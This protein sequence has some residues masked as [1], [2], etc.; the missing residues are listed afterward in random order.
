MSKP[1]E[2][3][4]QATV[5]KGGTAARKTPMGIEPEEFAKQQKAAAKKRAA[6][7]KKA[8]ASAEE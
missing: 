6:A 8:Q 5:V 1:R 7:K 4:P 3:V 2:K